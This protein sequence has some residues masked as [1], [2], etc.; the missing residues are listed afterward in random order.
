MPR[1][2]EARLCVVVGKGGV[3]RSTVAAALALA[4]ARAG[5]RVLVCEVN[6][7]ERISALLGAAPVGAAIGPVAPGIDAVDVEP[8]AAMRE[9]GLMVL[10]FRAIY[11]AVFENR[12][13]RY[14]LDAVPSLAEIVMLGKI[15]HHVDEPGADGAL[16]YDRVI[17]DAPATGHGLNLLRVPQVILD[18]VPPGPLARDAQRMRDLLVDAARSTAVLVTLPEEMPV[19]EAIEL[20]RGLRDVVR[21]DRACVVLNRYVPTRFSDGERAALAG[22]AVAGA[23]AAK[24]ARAQA[25]RAELCARYAQKLDVE[26][27]LPRLNVPDLPAAPFARAEVEAVALALE[28]GLA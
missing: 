11:E 4:H 21:M 27:E 19:N 15:L 26:V 20:D 23:A 1:P 16:R 5:R 7:R 13:V 24:A 25:A 22:L 6:T 2:L 28:A 8:H 12:F 14:F 10:R 3:G 9:Y 17:L 18:T